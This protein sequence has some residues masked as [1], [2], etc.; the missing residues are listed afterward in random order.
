MLY[1]VC[2]VY[3]VLSFQSCSL[4]GLL[5]SHVE[6]VLVSSDWLTARLKHEATSNQVEDIFGESPLLS[7][8]FYDVSLSLVMLSTV[9]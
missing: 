9:C 6:L 3:V 8:S 1:G 2:I 4:Q 7:L 5:F